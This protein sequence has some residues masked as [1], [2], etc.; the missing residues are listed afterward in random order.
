MVL[1]LGLGL[2]FRFRFREFWVVLALVLGLV[3]RFR[4]REFWGG[5]GL[6]LV[7]RFLGL[8]LDFRVFYLLF[9]TVKNLMNFIIALMWYCGFTSCQPTIPFPKPPIHKLR[10]D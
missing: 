2:V 6:G 7:F 10:L 8:C 4:F 5:F 9:Q 1:G 3:F